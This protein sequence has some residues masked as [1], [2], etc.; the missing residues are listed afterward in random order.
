MKDSLE[1]FQQFLLLKGLD[2]VTI[3]TYTN[4]YIRLA[5]LTKEYPLNQELLNIWLE[6]NTNFSHRSFIKNYLTF[7]KNHKLE[8]P[9]RTGRK[10]PKR[11]LTI[12]D[13]EANLLRAE[14]YSKG[15]KYG[16]M[17]DL[18]F[19]CGLRRS[20]VLGIRPADFEILEWYSNQNKPCVLLIKTAKFHKERKVV[21]PPE[22][23]KKVWIYYEIRIDN[24]LSENETLFDI[25]RSRWAKVFLEASEKALGKRYHLHNLRSTRATNWYKE[26]KDIIQIK[27]RLGHSSIA[28]TQL[29]INPEEEKEIERWK[30]EFS[31]GKQ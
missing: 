23:M 4:Y 19:F 31:D 9:R 10:A 13:S 2:K 6:T 27:N 22:I 29:Y 12:P 3:Q 18:S 5:D 17:F 14:L 21:I 8:I 15:Y 30:D 20:E 16:L 25:K 1:N 28:T 26:G 7:T 11:Q 24:M